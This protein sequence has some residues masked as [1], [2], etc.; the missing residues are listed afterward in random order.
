[1]FCQNLFS[2]NI[3]KY[4]FNAATR[5][6][7]DVAFQIDRN[8]IKQEVIDNSICTCVHENTGHMGKNN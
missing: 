4:K 5:T 8:Y 3:I 1:M 6:Q 2:F 7:I